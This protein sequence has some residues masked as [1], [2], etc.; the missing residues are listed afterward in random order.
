MTAQQAKQLSRDSFSQEKL[1]R[2]L[3]Q[4]YTNIEAAAKNGQEKEFG[5]K[6]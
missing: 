6:I 2:L 1:D 3:A 4:A 5:I